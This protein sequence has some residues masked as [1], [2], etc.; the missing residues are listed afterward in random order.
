MVNILKNLLRPIYAPIANWHYDTFKGPRRYRHLY[1][2]IKITGAK[3]ILEIGVWNGVRA[4]KMLEVASEKNEISSLN[5]FGFDLFEEMDSDVYESEISKM[6]PSKADVQRLLSETGA[7]INLYAGDTMK[8]LPAV[9][10]SLPKMDFIY[11]DGGHS[12]ETVAN[13]WKYSEMLM[14]K[15]TVVIFDDYWENRDDGGCKRVIDALDRDKYQV[16]FSSELDTFEN[17]D[18]G[19]LEIRYAIVTLK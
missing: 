1:D 2:Q 8:T 4:K 6:P 18:F 5:Y 16:D 10:D 9:V 7:S 11:I 3:N 14:H 12:H 17:K 19:R 13:D 15:D